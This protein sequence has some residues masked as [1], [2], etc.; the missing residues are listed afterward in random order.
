M[1][2]ATKSN[3]VSRRSFA[4]VL[5]GAGA[6]APL[7]AQQQTT[8]PAAGLPTQ[9]ASPQRPGR[10]PEIAPFQDPIEFTH[11]DVA[12]KIQPFAMTQVRLS[13]GPFQDAQDWNR[14][15]MA[16]LPA[17]R[18]TYNFLMNAGLPATAQP[19]GG[20]ERYVDPKLPRTNQDGELRGHFT[21]HFLS[22]SAQ[23]WASTGD[24]EAKAKADEMVD[25]LARCQTKLG[26]GGYLSAF[27]SE[28]FDRLDARQ[29]VWAPFYTVHKIMAG[30]FDM[31]RLAGNKQALQ[32]VSGM[33]DWA[34]RWTASK[35]EEHMQDILRTEYGGMGE[36]LYNL[37]AATGNEK[38]AKAGDR[39]AKKI[40]YNPLALRRD[41]LRGLHV[42]TH[43][44]QV[45]AAARRYEI[46]GDYRFHDVADYFWDEVVG[47]RSYVTMGTSDAEGWQCEPRQLAWE[48][49]NTGVRNGS[50]PS[51]NTAECCCAYNM[52]KLTRHLYGWTGQPRY[53]DYYER[54]LL[55][56]RLGTIEPHT[57]HTAVLPFAGAHRSAQ[58]LQQ[59]FRRFL[60]L[61]RH[62]RRGVLQAQRQHLLARRTRAVRKPVHR[63][64]AELGREGLQTAAGYQIPAAAWDCPGGNRGETGPDGNAATRSGVAGVGSGGEVERQGRRRVG[65]TGKLPDARAGLESRRPGGDGTADASLGRDSAR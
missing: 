37:A 35:T 2:K 10:P 15:Y 22:A 64:G 43:I 29:S 60:V 48:L 62:R 39:Y 34:D 53:F 11:K 65:R 56:H 13:A 55:N 36:V 14:A 31:Y 46:S 5:A 54:S 61:H 42:N 16:K 51:P 9:G 8:P 6:A 21:G 50:Q 52:L 59:R 20:W 30:M 18:L 33:A 25:V 44:P 57:G 1:S 41:E 26:A 27:P 32:V 63:L 24:K 7:L 23:L 49:K 4:A 58:E 12:P 45:I 40:F 19:L 38:W 3:R 17:D 28:F 47:A